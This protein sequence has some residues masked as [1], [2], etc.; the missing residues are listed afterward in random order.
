MTQQGMPSMLRGHLLNSVKHRVPELASAVLGLH[1]RE[2]G[3]AHAL[4]HLPLG[5]H[6]LL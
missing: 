6:D 1:K 2:G 5:L 4:A 3:L